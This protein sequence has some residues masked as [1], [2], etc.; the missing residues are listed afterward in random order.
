MED[1]ILE[2]EKQCR[3]LSGQVKDTKEQLDSIIDR[4]QQDM[5]ELRL[6]MQKIEE[7]VTS[8]KDW[9]VQKVLFAM[10][11]LYLLGN[12][13]H[14]ALLD[15]VSVTKT[16]EDTGALALVDSDESVM[17][18]KELLER[19]KPQ[20][21]EM[22]RVLEARLLGAQKILSRES[23]SVTSPPPHRDGS[24]GASHASEVAP[25]VPQSPLAPSSDAALPPQSPVM[26]DQQVVVAT[27][28][29]GVAPAAPTTISSPT[30]PNTEALEDVPI[31]VVGAP[32]PLADPTSPQDED[33]DQNTS[34]GRKRKAN[35]E[36]DVDIARKKPA[37]TRRK[38]APSTPQRKQPSRGR[39]KAPEGDPVA[40]GQSSKPD[41]I[42]EETE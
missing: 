34:T 41:I 12:S 5:V 10:E 19:A 24:P 28:S 9:T 36:V 18:V 29:D 33:E 15:L 23:G 6:K 27:K 13:M 3:T 38:A 40:Q 7:S 8:T 11:S 31:I 30:A 39:S 20:W 2:L 26:A 4:R 32:S 42:M 17:K 22:I 25:I 35:E 1:R 14:K 37:S 16:P 21:E